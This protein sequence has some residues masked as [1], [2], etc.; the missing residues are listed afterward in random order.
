MCQW[1]GGFEWFRECEFNASQSNIDI[2]TQA[3]EPYGTLVTVHRKDDTDNDDNNKAIDNV[4]RENRVRMI[5]RHLLAS[6]M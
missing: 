4:S 6:E 1:A 5:K 3:C 2:A